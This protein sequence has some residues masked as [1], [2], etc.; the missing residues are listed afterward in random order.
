M[1]M[2]HQRPAAPG[3][4]RRRGPASA[5]EWPGPGW[6]GLTHSHPVGRLAGFRGP[7]LVGY[8]GTRRV[9]VQAVTASCESGSGMVGAI[10]RGV[11]RIAGSAFATGGRRQSGRP[12]QWSGFVRPMWF[13][14]RRARGRCSLCR[15][16]CAAPVRPDEDRAGEL[17][18]SASGASIEPEHAHG[19]A[20]SPV[21]GHPAR[22][23]PE[24]GTPGLVGD[25][26]DASLA[27]EAVRKVEDAY[28][29][30][31]FWCRTSR[32]S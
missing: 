13:A 24:D 7:E 16:R 29:Q 11:P 25:R 31:S 8:P 19:S 10:I 12:G 17:S 32:G 23:I 22:R 27:A 28:R 18:L 14:A 26:A 1:R 3:R 5:R 4:S 21:P 9:R 30:R 2:R 15:L 6:A 20:G